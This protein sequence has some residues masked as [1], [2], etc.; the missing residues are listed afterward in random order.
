MSKKKGRKRKLDERAGSGGGRTHRQKIEALQR[1]PEGC[2]VQFSGGGVS[3]RR[4]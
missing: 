1:L 4:S 3:G 2:A